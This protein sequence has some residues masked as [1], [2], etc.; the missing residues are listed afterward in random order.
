MP[1]P[2]STCPKRT[3]D[4]APPICSSTGRTLRGRPE[5]A[6]QVGAGQHGLRNFLA[7]DQE[8]QGIL[9]ASVDE[10]MGWFRVSAGMF[11]TSIFTALSSRR[12]NQPQ[13]LPPISNDLDG[14]LHFPP[15]PSTSTIGA[16]RTHSSWAVRQPM[17]LPPP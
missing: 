5:A 10:V 15:C 6:G 11:A 1:A 3:S 16:E 13:P 12:I 2:A 9:A 14:L 8:G 4:D 7:A 17:P